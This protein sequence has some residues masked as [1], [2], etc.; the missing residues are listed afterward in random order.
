MNLTLNN[1]RSALIRHKFTI[2]AAIIIVS[3]LVVITLQYLIKITKPTYSPP[4]ASQQPVVNGKLDTTSSQAQQSKASLDILK[5]KLPY[6]QTITTSTGTKVTYSVFLKTPDPYDLYIETSGIDFTLKKDAPNY[7]QTVQDFRDIAD[8][9]FG[10]LTSS[11]T[12]PSTIYV[13]WADNLQSQK[14][15]E[16]WLNP[17]SEF[18]KV[19]KQNGKYIFKTSQ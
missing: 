15:A 9:V 1:L 10:F 14:T 2:F 12:N 3:L 8:S 19:V 16:S 7:T 6:N 17:S 5:P 18:P 11:G 13:V 4:P